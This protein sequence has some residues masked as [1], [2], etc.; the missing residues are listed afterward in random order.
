[1]CFLFFSVEIPVCL[2]VAI[3]QSSNVAHSKQFYHEVGD[4][5]QT[6]SCRDIGRISSGILICWD[7]SIGSAEKYETQI[8]KSLLINDQRVGMLETAAVGL[9]WEKSDG[10]VKN[11]LW[12]RSVRFRVQLGINDT[13]VLE[14]TLQLSCLNIS[15][16]FGLL[17]HPLSSLILQK[18]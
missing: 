13:D 12:V 16:I 2:F 4:H 14:Q 8:H 11:K 6:D 5:Q 7:N 18:C 10:L 3:E 9:T 17:Y 15:F 1:M